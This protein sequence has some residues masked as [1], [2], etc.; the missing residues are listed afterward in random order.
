MKT[1]QSFE[2]ENTK[3]FDRF[4]FALLFFMRWIDAGYRKMSGKIP[5]LTHI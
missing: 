5:V 2:N 4:Y 1:F 3:L